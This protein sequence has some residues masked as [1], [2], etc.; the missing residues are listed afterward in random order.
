MP[1]PVAAAR[2]GKATVTYA[3]G[4][5]FPE[6]TLFGEVERLSASGDYSLTCGTAAETLPVEFVNNAGNVTISAD[7]N[8]GS[9][10]ADQRLL[11]V[12][13]RGNLTIDA[14]KTLT[15]AARKL[16]LLIFCDGDVTVNGTLSMTAR[17]ANHSATGSNLTAFDTM[18]YEVSTAADNIWP[19]AGGAG[20]TSISGSGAS[21]GNV[22]TAGANGATGGG[23]SGGAGGKTPT[24]LVS[25][26]GATGSGYSGGPGGGGY[27]DSTGNCVGS[28][29]SGTTSGGAGGSALLY[30]TENGAGGGAGNPGGALAGT[31]YAGTS[32]CAGVIVIIAGGSITIGAM[33]VIC[34]NGSAGG[35]PGNTSP[36]GGGG[37]SGGGSIS[38]YHVGTY[39]NGGTVQANGGAGGA[40]EAY[41]RGGGAGGAG[42]IREVTL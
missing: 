38:L 4:Y 10:T 17:G 30:G 19:A 25:G 24:Y 29:G 21:I 23:G 18:L 42:S 16:G 27:R 1:Y 31:G 28:A 20:G 5:T 12:R 8:W 15:T 35:S 14:T 13:V 6:D 41:P 22:G 9:A 34:S 7:T 39:T 37:G 11:A 26:A 40:I 33:G 36:G 2:G 32:G 3:P